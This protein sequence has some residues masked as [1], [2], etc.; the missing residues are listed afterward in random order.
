[1]KYS[2]LFLLSFLV[3]SCKPSQEN[4]NS[5]NDEQST[6]E[7]VADSANSSSAENLSIKDYREFKVLD[8]KYINVDDLWAPF[9]NDLKD[10]TEDQYN[11]LKPLVLEKDIPTLQEEIRNGK[12]TYENLVKFYLYRIKKFDRKN[13][14]SL[15]SVIVLNPNVISE[16]KQKDRDLRNRMLKSPIFGMPILL[17][18]NITLCNL[19][20]NQNYR[21]VFNH[22]FS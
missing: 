8:S 5:A 13:E 1:M 20:T 18:D 7:V 17:K 19:L 6:K 4:K 10:F 14:M 3:F 22:N 2:I 11:S 16:A 21:Q 12:L 15:N 9:E